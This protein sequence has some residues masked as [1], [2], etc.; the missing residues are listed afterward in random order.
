MKIP[1][2]KAMLDNAV[3]I[4]QYTSG[5]CTIHRRGESNSKESEI[6]EALEEVVRT[7]YKL[8]YMDALMGEVTPEQAANK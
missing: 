6:I 4:G 3:W 5:T 1:N 8:G 2:F 7:A